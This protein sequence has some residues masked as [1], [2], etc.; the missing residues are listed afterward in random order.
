MRF[1]RNTRS[2]DSIQSAIRRIENCYNL[3]GEGSELSNT[4]AE[5]DTIAIKNAEIIMIQKDW[6]HW[7]TDAIQFFDVNIR[8]GSFIEP[9]GCLSDAS[10]NSYDKYSSHTAADDELIHMFETKT[11]NNNNSNNNIDMLISQYSDPLFNMI[12]S[13]FYID[14]RLKPL[15]NRKY[16]G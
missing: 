1:L 13:L 4:K 6:L 8:A 7:I 2:V 9:S 14:I 5:N 11:N 10:T 15:P 16:L 12:Q 3:L